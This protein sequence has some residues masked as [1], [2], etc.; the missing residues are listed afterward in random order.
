[1]LAALVRAFKRWREKNREYQIQRALYRESTD[2][3]PPAGRAARL[4]PPAA[5]HMPDAW[6]SSEDE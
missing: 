3:S 2:A 5:T 6:Q 4:G 1:M